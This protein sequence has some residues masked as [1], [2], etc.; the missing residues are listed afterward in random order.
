MGVGAVVGVGV[1]VVVAVGVGAVVAVGVGA[2][3]AVGVGAGLRV[4]DGCDV[5][6]G[7]DSS[8]HADNKAV[9][10]NHSRPINASLLTV[11]DKLI[12]TM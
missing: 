2:G 8:T 7:G 1:D 4:S 10:A 5:G 11:L 6:V 9:A 12:R 3:A